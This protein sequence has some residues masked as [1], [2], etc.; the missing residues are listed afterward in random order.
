[1][2]SFVAQRLMWEHALERLRDGLALHEVNFTCGHALK[3]F[4][5]LVSR[6]AA[7]LSTPA[8]QILRPIQLILC[9]SS[10]LS[11]IHTCW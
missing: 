3:A 5:D 7:T 11:G 9:T 4:T 6:A 8:R 1:M 2:H 10:V